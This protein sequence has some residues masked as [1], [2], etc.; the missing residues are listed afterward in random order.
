MSLPVT[1]FLYGFVGVYFLWQGIYPFYLYDYYWPCALTFWENWQTLTAAMIALCASTIAMHVVQ[2]KE[3]QKFRRSYSAHRAF[4]SHSLT[5]IID[6]CEV[7][8]QIYYDAFSQTR[9][10]AQ[11]G[12]SDFELDELPS[13]PDIALRDIFTLMEYADANLSKRLGAI[14]KELQVH[15]SRM[16]SHF[17]SSN[18]RHDLTSVLDINLHHGMYLACKIRYLAESLYEFSRF[19]TDEIPE[20]IFADEEFYRQLRISHISAHYDEIKAFHETLYPP[21]SEQSND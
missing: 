15:N 12:F 2:Y 9:N 18:R 3:K 20:N 11:N 7:S 6:Y 17:L 16:K 19:E 4:L 5:A 21:E 13:T 10:I 1:C 8:L 14:I